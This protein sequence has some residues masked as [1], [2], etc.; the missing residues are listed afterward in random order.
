MSGVKNWGFPP[1]LPCPV[2]SLIHSYGCEV[3]CFSGVCERLFVDSRGRLDSFIME[4]WRCLSENWKSL[5]SGWKMLNW[6]L[7]QE[8]TISWWNILLRNLSP[9]ATLLPIRQNG[10]YINPA[11]KVFLIPNK[12]ENGI[13]AQG[14]T[15]SC[16]RVNLRGMKSESIF[17]KIIAKSSIRWK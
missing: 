14:L 8:N 12:K 2:R 11:H 4:E 5:D 6:D 15:L 13:T 10:A 7:K 17:L 1:A 9:D 16:Q 3:V